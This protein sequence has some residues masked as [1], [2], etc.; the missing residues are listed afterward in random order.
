MAD[1]LTAKERAEKAEAGANP[2][3]SHSARWT[4]SPN[5][6]ATLYRLR[7]IRR[8]HLRHVRTP[9]QED[10]PLWVRAEGI[11]GV[12]RTQRLGGQVAPGSRD[13]ARLPHEQ[14]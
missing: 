8:E 13:Y 4:H 6:R 9:P 14:G 11:P 5:T 3:R 1:D 12:D 2:G 10:M 7:G